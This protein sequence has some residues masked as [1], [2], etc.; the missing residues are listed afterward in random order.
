MN[1][2]QAHQGH[3]TTFHVEPP[4]LTEWTQAY[5]ILDTATR[6]RTLRLLSDRNKAS[7]MSPVKARLYLH[8]HMLGIG[9]IGACATGYALTAGLW[10]WAVLGL[11]AYTACRG[12]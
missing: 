8:R 11:V 7:R 4:T 5:A 2:H 3:G 1:K 12:K 6:L 9:A 10:G